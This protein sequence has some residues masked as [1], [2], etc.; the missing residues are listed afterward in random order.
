[1]ENTTE[2]KVLVFR[3]KLKEIVEN[4]DFELNNTVKSR[5]KFAK[6]LKKTFKSLNIP[7]NIEDIS[8]SSY[9]M[10]T[11]KVLFRITNLETGKKGMLK[12]D[13]NEEIFKYL[14]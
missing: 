7:I 6:N 9:N 14:E 11:S 8:I 4:Q 3:E 5:Q 1:M 10:E 2:E 12:Y 13:T